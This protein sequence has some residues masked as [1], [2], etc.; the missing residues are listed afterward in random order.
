M[1]NWDAL[2]FV[3]RLDLM[4][5]TAVGGFIFQDVLGENEMAV[6]I[7]SPSK[8]FNYIMN[9]QSLS[10]FLIDFMGYLYSGFD[11]KFIHKYE[12][13]LRAVL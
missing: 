11:S 5:Q 3:Q 8:L 4:A 10:A 1:R 9:N 6:V 7:V 12:A 2:L 13:N